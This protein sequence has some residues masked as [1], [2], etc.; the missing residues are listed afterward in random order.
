VLACDELYADCNHSDADGCETSTAD[1][2]KNCG[3]CGN[4]CKDGE[5]CWRGACGCPSGYTQCGND[6]KKLDSDV[7]NCGSCGKLCRAPASPDDP[8]WLCGPGVTPPNTKWLCA[9]AAC[10]QQCAP[11]FG[12][13]NNAFCADGCE[14]DLRSDPMNCGACGR[15]CEGGQACVAGACICPAGTW[16]CG[17]ECV[18]I[19]TDPTNC[20]ECGNRCPGPAATRPG[21]PG[22]GSPACVGGKCSYVCF[23]GFADCD[24][25][26]GNGCEVNLSSDPQHCGGC[27]TRCNITAGQPCV[28]GQCL[29]RECDA[30]VVF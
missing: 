24:D 18:D 21:R 20:G 4:K 1:D 8:A 3:F 7:D 25:F 29:T 30:G 17:D 14:I 5:L 13:C 16:R 2:P 26:V 12:D 15:K 28:L 23:P 9:S 11:G 19:Q 6:C 27:G 10:T 22:G